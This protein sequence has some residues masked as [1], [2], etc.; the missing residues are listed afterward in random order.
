MNPLLARPAARA[1][2][3]T[4]FVAVLLAAVPARA[5]TMCSADF[6][7]GVTLG[8]GYAATSLDVAAGNV[9]GGLVLSSSDNAFAGSFGSPHMIYAG[10]VLGRFV[11]NGT[12]ALAGLAGVQLD[13]GSQGA[14]AVFTPDV[15]LAAAYRVT[16]WGLPMVVRLALSVG[17]LPGQSQ[18]LYG[19]PQVYDPTNPLLPQS[20]SST[21]LQNIG[22]GPNTTVG[23]AVDLGKNLEVTLGG[24]TAV[25][26]RYTL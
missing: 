6:K 1:L 11:D 23:V 17:P 12:I 21:W 13:P 7:P 16:A 10:R 4:S 2:A 8:L 20:Q 15:G 19:S 9:E 26:L 24:G 25:G 5:A 3:A 14:A 18:A 22:L